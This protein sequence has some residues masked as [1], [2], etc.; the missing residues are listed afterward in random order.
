MADGVPLSVEVTRALS[1]CSVT[2]G[3]IGLWEGLLLGALQKLPDRHF[4][5]EGYGAPWRGSC[6]AA[7][8]QFSQEPQPD[9]KHAFGAEALGSLIV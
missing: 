7:T 9:G 8:G 2:S 1:R 3:A 5:R 6:C 4:N